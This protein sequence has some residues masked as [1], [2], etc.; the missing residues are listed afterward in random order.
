[1]GCKSLF[2]F[3]SYRANFMLSPR[4][5][6]I[7]QP[8]WV[9]IQMFAPMGSEQVLHLTQTVITDPEWNKEGRYLLVKNWS[10]LITLIYVI[11]WKLYITQTNYI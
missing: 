6:D 7:S 11:K 10:C 8:S 3:S 5:I 4:F 9:N 2:S 1:M